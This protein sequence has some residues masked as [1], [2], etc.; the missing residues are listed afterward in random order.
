VTMLLIGGVYSRKVAR[1][2]GRGDGV[3]REAK[4][5]NGM[6][7]QGFMFGLASLIQLVIYGFWSWQHHIA[8]EA[9]WA[10]MFIVVGSTCLIVALAAR[11]WTLLG[12]AFPFLAYGLCLP[13]VVGAGK[14]VLL[15]MMFIAVALSFS[16]IQAMQIRKLES[17]HAAH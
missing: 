7:R 6:D 2:D 4:R 9:F 5:L 14:V 8:F 12:W 10:G 1:Q 16:L 3:I 11:A 13:L 15:G 17:E